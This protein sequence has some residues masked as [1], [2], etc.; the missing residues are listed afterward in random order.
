MARDSVLYA[1]LKPRRDGLYL[2][3]V[4]TRDTGVDLNPGLEAKMAKEREGG[5]GRP[6][7]NQTSTQRPRTKG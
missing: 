5:S 1:L 4:G 6:G 2:T 3:S 7:E